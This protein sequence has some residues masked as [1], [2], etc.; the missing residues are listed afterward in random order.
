MEKKVLWLM[1]VAEIPLVTIPIYSMFAKTAKKKSL[2]E[3]FNQGIRLLK[4][5]GQYQQIIDDE[6]SQSMFE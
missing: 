1:S 2:I 5:N 4:Q 6:I 3:Q